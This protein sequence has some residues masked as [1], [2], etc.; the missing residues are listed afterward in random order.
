MKKLKRSLL[1]ICLALVAITTIAF[2]GT[3][4]LQPGRSTMASAASESDL[5]FTLQ[6][7]GT[8]SVKAAK[9]DSLA[10]AQVK[11]DLIIPAIYNGKPV[12]VIEDRAFYQARFL[13]S[14]TIP[15]SIKRIGY[16]AFNKCGI[17]SLTIP[18]SVT[19]IGNGAFENTPITSITIPNSVTYVGNSAFNNCYK[20]TDITI[21]D[22]VTYV[23]FDVVW[24]TPYYDNTDNWE[25][26]V[27]YI[28]KHI[29]KANKSVISGDYEVKEG[30]LTIANSAFYG[31]SNI[32]SVTIPNSIVSIQDDAFQNCSKLKEIIF[33]GTRE[34]WD[35]VIKGSGAIPDSVNVVC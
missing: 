24:Q 7:D 11:G 14:V 16:S 9:I 13:T 25:N 18:N 30:T 17:K 33:K 15:N 28:G 2:A 19:Y 26:G 34:Q 20:L 31:C 29:I 5:T 23:G 35:A 27:L 4:L 12:T 3:F 32:T 1:T 10:G 6:S 21:P 22:S 8:Y